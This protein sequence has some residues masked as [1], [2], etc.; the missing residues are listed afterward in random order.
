MLPTI[1][2]SVRIYA[3]GLPMI[4]QVPRSPDMIFLESCT[5]PGS[6]GPIFL[7]LGVI[8]WVKTLKSETVHGIT[9]EIINLEEP[10]NPGTRYRVVWTDRAGKERN[11]RQFRNFGEAQELFED[12]CRFARVRR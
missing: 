2:K 1:R 11:Q 4:S 5:S 6:S 7:R 9:I 10:D 12:W 8:Y 3:G